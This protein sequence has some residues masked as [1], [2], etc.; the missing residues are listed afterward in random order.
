MSKLKAALERVKDEELRQ[1]LLQLSN[2]LE[3]NVFGGFVGKRL[4]FVR[5]AGTFLLSHHLGFVPRDAWLTWVTADSG[6]VT[7]VF[8]YAAFT[9]TQI[10]VTI[11]LSVPTAL[12]T[13]RGFCGRMLEEGV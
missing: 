4:V 1:V 8:N 2:G 10:S 12:C 13:F 6:T 11:T 7:V 3:E 9:K 5:G